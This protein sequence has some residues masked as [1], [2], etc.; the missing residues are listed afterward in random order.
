[1]PDL[2]CDEAVY[3]DQLVELLSGCLSRGESA[4]GN[5]PGLL[6]KVL[7]KEAWRSRT[8][9]KT[10]QEVVFTRFEDFVTTRPL[11]GLG[12]SMA[13]V[14]R[15]VRDDPEALD[16]LDRATV[17]P[18]HVHRE[19]DN[20]RVSAV[21]PEHGNARQYALRK[22]RKDAPEV[23]ARVLAG[24]LSAHAGMIEAG[25]RKKATALDQV[26]RLLGKLT[27]EELEDVAK[28]IESL[29]GVR[30]AGKSRSR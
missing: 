5:A 21:E 9:R 29:G 24:E 14:K 15:I 11:E 23:H 10:G 19:A 30:S 26:L 20:V 7:Q 13:L 6:K 4:L 25:F 16:L 28:R 1:M 3:A 18:A 17:A 22:L 27:P 8:I 2:P 12:A